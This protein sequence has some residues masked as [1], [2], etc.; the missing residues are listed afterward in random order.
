MRSWRRGYK[1]RELIADI[2]WIQTRGPG[3]AED[4]KRKTP[5]TL[6]YS[7]SYATNFKLNLLLL[8]GDDTAHRIDCALE[9]KLYIA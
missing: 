1:G 7:S 3:G 6:I 4:S 8:S 5:C 2:L 9:F